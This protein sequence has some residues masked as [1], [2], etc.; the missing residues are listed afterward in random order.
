MNYTRS[1]KEKIWTEIGRRLKDARKKR[2][3]SQLDVCR[4]LHISQGELSKLE[5]GTKEIGLFR[6]A[7]LAGLYGIDL[8]KFLPDALLKPEKFLT[9]PTRG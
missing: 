7:E 3:G 4:E 1:E 6:L 5:N 2:N 9:H 8:V